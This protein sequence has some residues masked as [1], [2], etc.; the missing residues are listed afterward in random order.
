M[1][2]MHCNMRFFQ[3]ENVLKPEKMFLVCFLKYEWLTIQD[4]KN[5]SCHKITCA[6]A[7]SH[8]LLVTFRDKITLFF[9]SY[10]SQNNDLEWYYNQRDVIYAKLNT[11][12]CLECTV[13]GSIYCCK[14]AFYRLNPHFI[15]LNAHEPEAIKA[16]FYN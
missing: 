8:L 10:R 15:S 12:F 3:I 5:G 4:L 7:F 1:N 13:N 2:D 11:S 16:N 9:C 14:I 6:S